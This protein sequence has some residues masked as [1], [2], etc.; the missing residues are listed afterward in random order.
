MRRLQRCFP[1]RL[2]NVVFQIESNVWVNIIVEGDHQ[3]VSKDR[4]LLNGWVFET[5]H[6]FHEEIVGKRRQNS[7][8][9]VSSE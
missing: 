9:T 3:F 1:A 5:R 4:H 7:Q 6:G 8:Q 2:Q